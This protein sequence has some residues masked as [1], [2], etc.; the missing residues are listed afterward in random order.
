MALFTTCSMLLWQLIGHGLSRYIMGCLC[1]ADYLH[2]LCTLWCR[3]LFG[4]KSQNT[5]KSKWFSYLWIFRQ[6]SNVKINNTSNQFWL[7]NHTVVI[8]HCSHRDRMCSSWIIYKKLSYCC[9]SRSYWLQ[10]YDRLKQLL[11]DTL[12][13]LTNYGTFALK[14]FRSRERK[15][16]V[17]N[18]RSR[19]RKCHGTFAPGSEN[20]V[21]LSFPGAKKLW[22]F[23]SQ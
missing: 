23:R 15:F 3:L 9:K 11:R 4:S 21:E 18:F 13:V 1:L 10:K 12:S 8:Y 16:Q 17:W 7:S 20:D 2:S 5:R 19:E 22:N 14:N 6:L